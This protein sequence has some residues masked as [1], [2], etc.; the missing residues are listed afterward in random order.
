M[1]SY[2]NQRLQKQLAFQ[3]P[4]DFNFT[5]MQAST[6]VDAYTRNGA[7]NGIPITASGSI[8]PMPPW[9]FDRLSKNVGDF[10]RE[11]L[12]VSERWSC[13]PTLCCAFDITSQQP[14]SYTGY[15]YLNNLINCC[16]STNY[17]ITLAARHTPQS[18]ASNQN[19]PLSFFTP[20]V[21]SFAEIEGDVFEYDFGLFGPY[22]FSIF[23]D[24]GQ[25]NANGTWNNILSLIV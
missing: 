8:A 10:R 3:T 11:E 20:F 7:L 22:K 14:G 16:A 25:H 23:R 24:N 1:Q 15:G 18:S 19:C 2:Q 4:D 9:Y 13:F 17:S 12:G 6:V 21:S 5:R